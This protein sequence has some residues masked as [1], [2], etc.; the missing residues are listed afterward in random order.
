MVFVIFLFV[1]GIFGAGTAGKAFADSCGERGTP[2]VDYGEDTAQQ[3]TG[4]IR[5]NQI[6]N[7]KII[8]KAADGGGLSGR[9]TLIGLMTALQESTLLNIDYG[10]L[11][12]IGL[13]QQRPSQGWGTETQIMQPKYAAGM[14]FF[15]ASRDTTAGIHGLADIQGWEAMGLGQA[16]QE[17][18]RSAY[19]ELYDGQEDAARKIAAEAGIDLDRPGKGD[20]ADE[21]QGSGDDTATM[22][23]DQDDAPDAKC[24]P[25]DADRP[26]KPGD[27]FHDGDAPWPATVKNPRSA[28]D[29]IAWAEKEAKTGG[30]DWYRACLAFVARAYGWSFSGVPYAID[31][32]REMPADM[33]H[34]KDRNPPPGALMYWETGGRAG[35]VAVYLGDGKIASNDI[36]R[37]GYI[38][39]VPATDI[40]TKWGSTY[41][42]WA[43]P[44]FPKGG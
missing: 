12:S 14:F 34:D 10:H 19:P 20:D 6:A 27:A 28:A 37:P 39:V 36:V 11:D 42:G 29:A 5:K 32:Y 21:D 23:P 15:G 35:H 13:F 33:K 8:D 16:A 38:D 24:Y 41:V 17:V 9:A 7:A 18:Q 40:E 2:G 4:N 31:H 44:Y 30:K 26:G 25:E 3:P 43:P 1:V 22:N